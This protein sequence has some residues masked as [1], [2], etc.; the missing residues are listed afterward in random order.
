MDINCGVRLITTDISYSKVKDKLPHWLTK[1]SSLTA[2][3]VGGKTKYI[4][5]KKLDFKQVLEHGGSICCQSGI[6]EFRR[7]R[8][9]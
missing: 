8:P 7:F 3:G 9:H 2:P 4:N 1:I 5:A 6:W